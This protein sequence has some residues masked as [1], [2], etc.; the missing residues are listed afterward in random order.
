MC[1]YLRNWQVTFLLYTLG[2]FIS[3]YIAKAFMEPRDYRVVF[4]I[5]KEVLSSIIEDNQLKT[6][7]FDLYM[8]DI[9]WLPY[10]AQNQL[11]ADIT[12][13]VNNSPYNEENFFS[14]NLRNCQLEGRYYGIPVVG[15]AQIM[16]YRKDLFED[17]LLNQKYEALYGCPLTLPQ[18]WETFNRIAR[19]FTQK[20]FPDSPTLYGTSLAGADSLSFAPEIF[21][22]MLS[23]HGNVWDAHYRIALNAPANEKAFASVLETCRY[24]EPGILNTTISKTV[25]N[26]CHGKTA[27]LI[28][29]TERAPEITTALT[30]NTIGAVGYSSV[31]GGIPLNIGWNLGVSPYTDKKSLIYK[32]L[33]WLGAPDINNYLTILDG[34]TAHRAPY[35]KPE[36]LRLYPWMIYTEESFSYSKNR[37]SP[38]KKNRLSIPQNKIDNLLYHT[39]MDILIHGKSIEEALLLAD[40][41]GKEL[42]KTYG[43][44]PTPMIRS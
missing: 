5:Q 6:P 37:I 41:K 33:D 16:F 8:Y 15:G 20:Y 34:Q 29:Y 7:F 22:R 3:E 32:Y 43:Y 2:V 12:D 1:F 28:T 23:Y 35:H 25:H 9:P 13:Y 36:F 21:L 10:L 30:R 38:Y 11:I 44:Y 42:L 17:P 40:R 39:F 19:Y 14:H 27:M 31:P 24:C 18:D 26:F 4:L